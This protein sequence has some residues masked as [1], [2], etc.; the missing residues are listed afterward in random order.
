MEQSGCAFPERFT[1]SHLITIGH[2]EVAMPG[3]IVYES[4]HCGHCRL[5]DQSYRCLIQVH[6]LTEARIIQ[7]IE[8]RGEHSDYDLL[9]SEQILNFTALVENGENCKDGCAAEG[10]EGFY[11]N[12]PCTQRE[13]RITVGPLILAGLSRSGPLELLPVCL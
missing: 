5:T 2:V 12:P 13:R 11:L 6:T 3:N 8:G 7:S 1:V 10:A 9:V 4:V